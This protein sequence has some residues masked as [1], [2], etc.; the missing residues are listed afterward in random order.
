ML[1][2]DSDES[3]IEQIQRSLADWPCVQKIAE[4]GRGRINEI[5]SKERQWASFE[6]IVARL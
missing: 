1:A 2:Y 5:Y 3:C 6:S 4:N